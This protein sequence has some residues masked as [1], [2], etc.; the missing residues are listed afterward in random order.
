MSEQTLVRQCA[1]C[2]MCCKVMRVPELPK[3]I[4]VWCTHCV[5]GQGCGIYETRPSSCREFNCLYLSNPTLTPIWKPSECKFVMRFEPGGGGRI[6]IHVDA[7]R[8][9]AWRQEPFLSTF[10]EWARIGVEHQAQVVVFVGRHVYVIVPDRVVD[11]G[12]I[13]PEEI[14]VTQAI[15]T[16]QGLQLEPFK[17]SKTDP[18]V[19]GLA[20]AASDSMAR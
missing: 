2:T 12:V 17:A 5:L 15:Q 10:H 4:N 11:L 1:G 14:I 19:Q 8:P 3:K 18:R 16:P 9:D 13:E 6:S 20:G 7:K